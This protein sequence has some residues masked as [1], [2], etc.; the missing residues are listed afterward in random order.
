MKPAPAEL[1]KLDKKTVVLTGGCGILGKHFSEALVSSGA[2]LAII[3]VEASKPQAVAAELMAKFPAQKIKGYSCDVSNEQNVIQTVAEI[4][5]DF[6]QMD[7][8]VNNAASKSSSLT[9]F[10]APYEQFSLETWREVMAVNIDGMF[11][12]S[13]EVGK[14]MKKQGKG[15]IIQIASI[16]GVVAPDQRIYEGSFYMGHTINTPAVYSASKAAVIGLSQ[17]LSTYWG[18]VGI[19]V[20]TLTPGGVESGQNKVFS[21]N[22]SRRVPLNRMAEPTDLLGALIYLA[23]DASSYVTGQNLI[24]DGGLTVW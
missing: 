4:A 23:S 5:K 19:R 2:N 7:V 22:Y 24:V 14:E 13:R 18:N 6:G 16:Y 12:M 21:D 3:D 1:F 8:L 11:L 10:F 20:N 17:Y 9:S 15:S